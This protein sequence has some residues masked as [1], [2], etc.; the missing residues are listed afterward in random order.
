MKVN[1]EFILRQVAD[2][3]VVLAL[4]NA[5]IDFSGMLTLNESGVML[6]QSLEQGADR[7]KLVDVLTAEYAVS[8]EVASQDVDEFLAKLAKAG[9]LEM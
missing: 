7:E 5:S 6:W 1:D 2:K 8:R 9:C 3:W 4:G